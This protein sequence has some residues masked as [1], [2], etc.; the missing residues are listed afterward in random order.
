MTEG[1]RPAWTRRHQGLLALGAC[2]VA[3]LVMTLWGFAELT[4]PFPHTK[5]ATCS[6]ADE[7]VT[8]T[9][10]RSEVTLSIYNAGARAG[11]AAKISAALTRLGFHVSVV[12]N[13]P[14]GVTVTTTE[15][16]G[17]SESDPATKLVAAALGSTATV[18]SDPALQ[19]GAGVN[20]YLGPH[21][22]PVLKSPPRAMALPT[23][24]VTCLSN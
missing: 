23:P 14:S 22:G 1:P 17:P 10:T 11:T 7:V 12:G 5:S 3:A 21:H 18:S 24:V 20:V 6:P 2:A 8:K 19:I 15:V 4:A 13:A 16:V 9:V